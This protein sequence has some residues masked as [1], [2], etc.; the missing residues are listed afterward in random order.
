MI[1]GSLLVVVSI[2]IFIAILVTKLGSRFGVPSLLLFLVLGM[3]IGSEG[4]GFHF[5][6]YVT[7]DS[8]C[9]F[10]VTVILFDAGLKTSLNETRPV[11]RQGVMLSSLGVL[12]TVLLTGLFIAFAFG[13]TFKA[14]V[15][16][17]LLLAAILGSTDSASVFS[18]LRGKRLHLREQ[19]APMLELES[20]SNDAMAYSLTLILVDTF[21]RIYVDGMSG[22]QAA[23]TG[24]GILLFQLTLG[25]VIGIGLGFAFKWLLDKMTLPGGV[26]NAILIVSVGLFANGA[27]SLLHANS[28]VAVY[29]TAII[30]G[31]KVRLPNEKETFNFFGGLAW[32]MQLLMFTLLGLLARPSL[33]LPVLLPAL[34]VG[35]FLIFIA[36][37]AAVMLTLLPFRKMS[38]RAKLFT[39][40][41]GIKGAGPILF[42]IAP[43]VAGLE[44]AS[45]IFDV[46]FVIV[47]FSLIL[48]GTTLRPLAKVL[49][50][51]Y[52]EDP[53]AE[54]FGLDI[55][56]EMGM[57]RDHTVT[58]EDLARGATLRE[59][60]LPHGIRVMMVRRG[61]RFLVPHGSMP[62]EVG[63]RLIIIMGES[64]D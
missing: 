57:L 51:S 28:L 4:L 15:V 45:Y 6:N 58:E 55:P 12:L 14:P 22:W 40:W 32:L 25:A 48:Q 61:E 54:T 59:L 10:A 24:A 11:F 13:N 26:L 46:V 49:H 23:L 33:M 53:Q 52:D 56:E 30:I 63:D 37:P 17:S 43:V 64:D 21:A 9:H 8:L 62:L 16:G 47:L 39:S 31:N 38:F 7:A 34:A 2:L 29:T 5:E 35:A 36:R 18:V 20:G 27:S 42:A 1:S 41:V 60:G 3:L 19:L 50:L 44:G